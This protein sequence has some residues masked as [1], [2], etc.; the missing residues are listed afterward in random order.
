MNNCFFKTGFRCH[1]IFSRLDFVSSLIEIR[2][3][4]CSSYGKSVLEIHYCAQIVLVCL[5]T[6]FSEG[7]IRLLDYECLTDGGRVGTKMV[8][9]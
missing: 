6:G 2:L 7:A 5:L 4:S 3:K 1:Y 8:G 9:F